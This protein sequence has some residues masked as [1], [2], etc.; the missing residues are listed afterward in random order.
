MN[1]PW[2]VIAELESDNSRLFKEGV[3]HREATAGNAELFRGFC[4]AYDAMVTFGVK[5]VDEKKGDGRGIKSESFWKTA[6]ELARRELTGNAALTA[7][8]YLRMNATEAEW[9]GWYRRILIKDMRCGTSDTTINKIVAKVNPDYL[10]PV[11][12]CQLA[13]DG[14]NHEGKVTGEKLV[15]VK[16]D[17]VRVITIVYPSGQVDQYSRNGKELLNF[18]H[19]KQQ[20]SKQARLFS[21]PMVLDGEVMSASF[22]DLMKQVHRKD[23]VEASDAVL[24]LFDILT[25]NEF[26]SGISRHNQL[27]RSVS[28]SMW[29]RFAADHMPNVAVVGQAL[30]DL[31]TDEGRTEFNQINAQAIA[32][33]YE[34]IMIK[35][36]AALYETKRSVAWLKQKPYIE[37]SLSVVNLEEG[38]GKNVGR[39]GALVCEGVDDGKEI[40]VNVGSG[41][42]DI[43]RDSFWADR[44]SVI[45]NIVEV[46]ADAVTQN[47]DG[48]YS[49]RFPRFKGFRGFVPGEKL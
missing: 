25:L 17:G 48:S 4:A 1:K 6:G 47:Q 9:N 40:R 11:F 37:V 26:Q 36:P 16:L 24:H 13:H 39:L 8:N 18:D 23:N 28:L 38:T 14:A 31:N 27:D 46:R 3:V 21:E 22:Q 35:D 19:I 5:K 43:D 12:T 42:T 34:G 49:L 15:E 20:I 7:V 32:G 10:I 2:E 33:G 30:L 44:R 45:G 41:F 29:Y